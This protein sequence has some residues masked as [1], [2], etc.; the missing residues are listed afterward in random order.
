[1]IKLRNLTPE[2]YSKQSRDFQFIERLF[3]VVLNSVKTN[4]ESLYN[5]PLNDNTDERLI[6]LMTLTLGFKSRHNYNVKQLT[7]LCSAFCEVLKNKGTIYSITAAGNALLNSEGIHDEIWVEYHLDTASGKVLFNQL[8]I[9]VPQELSDTN[10]LKDL[11]IYILPAG[12]TINL[13]RELKL[14]TT[15]ATKLTTDDK[16]TIYNNDNT[17]WNG[18]GQFKDINDTTTSVIPRITN[19]LAEP[20][21]KATPGFITNTTVIKA[22]ITNI[23]KDGE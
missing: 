6:E 19:N 15:A 4:S 10:L 5:L 9:F 16:I 14:N 23:K 2:V 17:P 22:G 1:M 8:D 11:L 12:V 13:I 20:T 3:D 7:A 18:G 21:A